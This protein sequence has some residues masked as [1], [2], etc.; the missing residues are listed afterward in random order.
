MTQADV[1]HINNFIDNKITAKIA[2]L[3]ISFGDEI[4]A[5]M[6]RKDQAV[7]D[8]VDTGVLKLDQRYHGCAKQVTAAGE[9]MQQQSG[10]GRH[11]L[12]RL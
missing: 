1:T 10:F 8:V 9:T 5:L 12:H 7:K 6:D 2:A 3:R 11:T 4:E